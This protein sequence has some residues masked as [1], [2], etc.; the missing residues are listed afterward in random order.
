MKKWVLINNI[1]WG[2]VVLGQ[3]LGLWVSEYRI[4]RKI[5]AK[6]AEFYKLT[7]LMLR[8]RRDTNPEDL[9]IL[10]FDFEL[11][12]D[13][14]FFFMYYPS[15][16]KKIT[17]MIENH[18]RSKY[19]NPPFKITQISTRFKI[20]DRDR[21]A[22]VSRN[23][24]QKILESIRD[25]DFQESLCSNSQSYK[26]IFVNDNFNSTV[27]LDQ[28]NILIIRSR[29]KDLENKSI[30]KQIM[31]QAVYRL[32]KLHFLKRYRD[33]EPFKKYIEIWAEYMLYRLQL[34]VTGLLKIN[35]NP[36]LVF[37]PK[38]LV[39]ISD[40]HVQ[41]WEHLQQ[42]FKTQHL[43]SP[44]FVFEFLLSHREILDSVL[45]KDDLMIYENVYFYEDYFWAMI[46]ATLGIVFQSV[47]RFTIPLIRGFLGLS[48]D[49]N[50]KEKNKKPSIISRVIDYLLEVDSE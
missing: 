35:Q 38:Y 37:Y 20:Y 3:F 18:L 29:L 6:T 36:D 45:E 26:I 34:Y 42:A 19:K 32:K 40:N 27:Y 33:P 22:G 4:R 14:S 23:D 15:I 50:K 44:E 16:S 1:F 11:H 13:Y 48:S 25:V 8:Q 30:L 7:E 43:Q 49:S 5:P 9:P 17:T 2:L 21:F 41:F 39:D 10:D 24:N 28:E 47:I 12:D 31:S 46:V